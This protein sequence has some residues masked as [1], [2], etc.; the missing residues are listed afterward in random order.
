MGV[1]PLSILYSAMEEKTAT[2]CF[3]PSIGLPMGSQREPRCFGIPLPRGGW[4]KFGDLPL[5]WVG[6]GAHVALLNAGRFLQPSCSRSGAPKAPFLWLK[7]KRWLH[8][9]RWPGGRVL[10]RWEKAK[11]VRR[12]PSALHQIK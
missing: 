11:E 10:L 4:V 7:Q 6:V 3:L 9:L 2:S 12:G 5:L 8:I 1:P